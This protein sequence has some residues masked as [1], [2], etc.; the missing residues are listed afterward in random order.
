MKIVIQTLLCRFAFQHNPAL[1]PRA[2][3]VLGCICK[4][5]T[6]TD[7]KQLLRIMSQALESYANELDMEKDLRHRTVDTGQAGEFD[8]QSSVARVLRFNMA[9][10]T[11]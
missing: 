3:I 5:F 8:L 1:Q 4:R 9:L 10:L 6:D 2:I 7:I 11:R